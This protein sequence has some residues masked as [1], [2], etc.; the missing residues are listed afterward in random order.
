M[1]PSQP[2]VGRKRQGRQLIQL[3]EGQVQHLQ[4]RREQSVATEVG[5]EV[6][7]EVQSFLRLKITVGICWNAGGQP[8]DMATTEFLRVS[9]VFK[10]VSM[11]KHPPVGLELGE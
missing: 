8:E 10:H 1:Q 9:W 3:V 11:L 6:P 5:E 4:G 2:H 7:G